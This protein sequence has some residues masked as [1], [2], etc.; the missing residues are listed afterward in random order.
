[1]CFFSLCKDKTTVES[2]KKYRKQWM[3]SDGGPFERSD[4]TR[5]Y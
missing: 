3:K 2:G 1:M 4:L 5:E